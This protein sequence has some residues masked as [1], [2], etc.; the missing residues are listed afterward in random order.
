MKRYFTPK[1][2]QEIDD[3]DD[4][5]VFGCN[6]ILS[7]PHHVFYGTHYPIGWKKTDN[8]NGAWNGVK[9]CQKSHDGFHHTGV[10]CNGKSLKENRQYLES[11]SQERY[12]QH[13]TICLSSREYQNA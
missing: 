4:K 11:L 6:G 10:F 1:I 7:H 12:E 3:R 5:C 13:L 9:I 8:I 2:K